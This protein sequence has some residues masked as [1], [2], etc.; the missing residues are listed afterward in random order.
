[1]AALNNGSWWDDSIFNNGEDADEEEIPWGLTTPEPLS[2]A[3][4][5]ESPWGDAQARKD[6]PTAIEPCKWYENPPIDKGA[7]R[8][9]SQTRLGSL[10]SEVRQII[11]NMLADTDLPHSCNITS[12]EHQYME[13]SSGPEYLR[14]DQCGY[15]LRGMQSVLGVCQEM[16]SF[17]MDLLMASTTYNC[18]RYDRLS[19]TVQDLQPHGHLQLIRKMRLG[20]RNL[21]VNRPEK[22]FPELLRLLCEE[23]PSLEHIDLYNVHNDRSPAIPEVLSG[24][25]DGTVSLNQ[26][27]TRMILQFAAFLVLR[28]PNLDVMTMRAPSEPKTVE[29]ILGRK[30]VVRVFANHVHERRT[31][32]ARREALGTSRQ[33]KKKVGAPSHRW[34]LQI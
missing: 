25:P 23:M 3:V 6:F 32:D 7:I 12:T 21:S 14:V 15:L 9:F 5:A 4:D 26:Q 22:H 28:H 11:W 10:P 27:E 18:C 13:D 16:R 24:D 33:S 34:M 30:T 1:M 20:L 31:L 17:L 19:A 29:E 2:M 8:P